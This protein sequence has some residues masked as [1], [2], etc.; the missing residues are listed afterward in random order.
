MTKPA[1]Q[2]TPVKAVNIHECMVAILRDLDA[3]TKDRTA[4]TGNFSYKFRGIDQ[5][6]NAI[7]PLLCKY[8]VYMTA[9]VLSKTREERVKTDDDKK[10]IT[11]FTSL[12]MLYRFNASDGSYVET[13]AEGEGMDSGD[14]SSNK[15]MSVAHKYAILQAFCVPTEDIAESDTEVHDNVAP[16]KSAPAPRPADAEQSVSTPQDTIS[17]NEPARA[18]AAADWCSLA[19]E[20][21]NEFGT[22]N[23]LNAWLTRMAEKIRSAKIAAPT[24]HKALESA[25]I[26]RTRTLAQKQPQ[27]QAAE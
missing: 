17:Q 25:I 9:K 4:G 15:A 12:H 20:H 5:I 16:R 27:A 3:I 22:A 7:N 11:A 18:K 13:E 14:K 6:Y 10:T 26:N 2:E 23:G 8:G 24:E 19:I 21:V 1:T